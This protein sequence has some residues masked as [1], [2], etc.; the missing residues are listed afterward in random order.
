MFGSPPGAAGGQEL[1]F[2]SAP[3]S[4]ESQNSLYQH[5]SAAPNQSGHVK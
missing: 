1:C 3:K 5:P 4:R 2:C